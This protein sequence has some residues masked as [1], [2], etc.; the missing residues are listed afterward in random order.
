VLRWPGEIPAGSE[1]DAMLHVVDLFPTFAGLAGAD[2]TAGR[3]LDGLD[4]WDAIA[5]GA[6]SP[7]NEVV[8]SLDVIR[9]GDWKLIEK[10]AYFYNS[11]PEYVQLFNIRADPYETR[12]LAARKPAKVAELRARLAHHRQFGREGEALQRIPNY[13]PVVYG[14]DENEEFAAEV[15]T[16]RQQ[17]ERGNLGPSL[18]HTA[19]SGEDVRLVYDETLDA[20]SVPAASAFRVVVNPGYRSAEVTAVTVSGSDVVLTLSVS[21][22]SGETVG[23]TYEVPDTGA[24]RDLEGVAAVGV[25]WATTLAGSFEEVPAHDGVS[26]FRL[27]LRFS[28]PVSTSDSALVDSAFEVSG[29]RITQARQVEGS[30]ALW[31][32]TLVPAGSLAVVLT[33]P[34]TTDCA[35]SGAVCMTD[36]KPLANRTRTTIPWA[37]SSPPPAR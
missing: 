6:E 25:T 10:D 27:R 33:L 23:V 19:R 9:V 5:K 1:T 17:R 18:V 2:T 4:A 34:V 11:P 16:A 31:E 22:Q 26:S 30:G 12:P 20:D 15:R 36:A 14:V 13:P 32:L 3:P 35:A 21:V 24:I 37:G 8:H 29:G 7:R 28:E